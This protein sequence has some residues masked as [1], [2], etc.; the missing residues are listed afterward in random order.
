MKRLI[1]FSILFLSYTSCFSQTGWVIQSTPFN[2]INDFQ[3]LNSQTGFIAGNGG[4]QFA[5]TTNGG[6]TWT[7]RNVPINQH[8]LAVSF[9]NEN[10]GWV[11]CQ[12]DTI[13]Y[14]KSDIYKTSNG[15]VT[16]TQ[17]NRIQYQEYYSD[18]HMISKDSVIITTGGWGMFAN[19]GTTS[20]TFNGAT[21]FNMS[22]GYECY[23]LQFLNKTTGW[24]IRYFET[25]TGPSDV[26]ISK[27]VN[28]GLS[29]SN[30]YNDHHTLS[31]YPVKVYNIHFLN[32]NTGYLCGDSGRFSVT[33]NGGSNWVNRN[34]NKTFGFKSVFFLDV[35]TGYAGGWKYNPTVDSSALLRTTNGGVNWIPMRNNA[36]DKIGKIFFV[37]D[38]TGWATGITGTLPW[39][40]TGGPLMKT[41]TGGLTAIEPISSVIPD[42]FLL[43][44]NY[45]NPF[46]PVT[47]IQYDIP[48]SNFVSLKVYD[49]RGNEIV[50]LVSERQNAGSYSITFDA[51]SKPSGVYFYKLV[52]SGF[53]ETKK[54]VLIK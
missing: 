18:L 20:Y 47:K 48:S 21:P 19:L 1:L 53:T 33:T 41:V 5:V 31:Y 13:G 46:N 7:S 37:D 54:M 24:V 6:S 25:D 26:W 40:L 11:S 49:V 9:I 38:H 45:P 12:I 44:Q 32:E 17:V 35:N 2:N 10:T 36:L 52:T 51:A 4:G 28:S 29:W 23:G 50:T 42:K 30:I 34:T 43:K 14:H 27:T 8:M 16:W 22:N 3:F 15:G 39:N